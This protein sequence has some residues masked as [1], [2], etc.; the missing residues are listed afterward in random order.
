M[1]ASGYTIKLQCHYFL[2]YIKHKFQNVSI[3]LYKKLVK[4]TFRTCFAF[5]LSFRK[6]HFGLN[7]SPLNSCNK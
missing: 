4:E 5:L 6:P 2:I 1:A 3:T 7:V